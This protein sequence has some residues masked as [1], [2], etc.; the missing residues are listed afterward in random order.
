M[1]RQAHAS[2][3]QQIAPLIEQ[4]IHEIAETLTGTTK[5]EENHRG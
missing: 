2:E 3:A 5:R 1:I 4:A